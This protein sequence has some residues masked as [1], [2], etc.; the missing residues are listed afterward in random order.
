M[1]LET[2]RSVEGKSVQR[3][4]QK[5]RE[6]EKEK[7]NG[8]KKITDDRL[9]DAEN[10]YSYTEDGERERERDREIQRKEMHANL[11]EEVG[12]DIVAYDDSKYLRST[13]L[14]THQ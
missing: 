3:E 4:R 2:D 12:T 9:F 6:R 10:K 1:N 5:K 11:P 13:P 14:C 8:K 7:R